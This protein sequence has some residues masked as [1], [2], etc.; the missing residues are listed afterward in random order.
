MKVI[1]LEEHYWGREVAGNFTERW[2]EMRVPALQERLYDLG[3][4]R[5]KEMD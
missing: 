3:A 5:L 1:A 4:L 2:P